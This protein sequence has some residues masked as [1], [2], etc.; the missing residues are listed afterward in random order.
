MRKLILAVLFIAIILGGCMPAAFPLEINLDKSLELI[1]EGSDFR[2]YAH[3]RGYVFIRTLAG[4]HDALSLLKEAKKD[5]A[6]SLAAL[7]DLPGKPVNTAKIGFNLPEC[8]F[9]EYRPIVVGESNIYGIISEIK[10][11]KDDHYRES[12]I[13][14][15]EGKAYYICYVSKLQDDTFYKFIQG[16][17]PEGS[18]P[19][20]KEDIFTDITITGHLDLGQNEQG[21]PYVL[22]YRKKDE[23]ARAARQ[24][25]PDKQW[26]GIVVNI[27]S[28]ARSIQEATIDV[29]AQL[30]GKVYQNNSN[31]YFNLAAHEVCE[32]SLRFP[33]E[34]TLSKEQIRQLTDEM[35]ISLRYKENGVQQIKVIKEN[36]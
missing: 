32:Y 23:I 20:G 13:F 25:E 21:Q 16:I 3:P 31:A 24:E 15:T 5:P 4:S 36:K 34:K 18:S 12:A 10:T 2:L 29:E 22:V 8:T 7:F 14:C 27:R 17:K 9:S 35:K 19:A 11:T 26:L 6:R 1:K 30:N 33:V 28:N